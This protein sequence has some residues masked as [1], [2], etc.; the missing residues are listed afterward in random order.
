M[1]DGPHSLANIHR[2]ICSQNII[3]CTHTTAVFSSRISTTASAIVV[4]VILVVVFVF[5]FLFGRVYVL[6]LLLCYYNGICINWC[7]PIPCQI[8]EMQCCLACRVQSLQQT[9]HAVKINTNNFKYCL[10][11][12]FLLLLWILISFVYFSL[13]LSFMHNSYN[14]TKSILSANQM[15]LQNSIMIKINLIQ[16]S[17]GI[18]FIQLKIFQSSCFFSL[19]SSLSTLK[20]DFQHK[21]VN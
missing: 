21:N 20:T 18:S 16:F 9:L 14:R 11:A 17:I 5:S 1:A 13:S 7:A 3:C 15:Q 19:F 10:V 6:M 4:A 2:N 8:V 12:P